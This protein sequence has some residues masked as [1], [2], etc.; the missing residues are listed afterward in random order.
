[1]A[2]VIS[3]FPHTLAEL[4]D[5]V[6]AEKKILIKGAGTSTVLPF[7]TINQYLQPEDELFLVSIDN[8]P[9]K[10]IFNESG[11]LEISG[12]VSWSEAR[13]FLGDKKY[14]L[15]L[16]PT[17]TSAYILAGLATQ[18]SGERSFKFGPLKNYV[19]K[20]KVIDH[21]G[22][23]CEYD[24]EKKYSGPNLKM[25]ND[26]Y[27]HF[28]NTML[29]QTKT[30]VDPF[31]GSEGQ[32]GIIV[33]CQLKLVPK[34]KSLPFFVFLPPW[35]EGENC[36][37]H[38]EILMWVKTQKNIISC[39]LMDH[40]SLSFISS[41]RFN[42]QKK[43]IIFFDVDINFF[44]QTCHNLLETCK[45]INAEDV[46]Q[47][48]IAELNALRLEIPRKVADFVSNNK[49]LKKGTDVQVQKEDFE[50]LLINYK[51]M[52]K[53]LNSRGLKFLLFG[54][55]GDCHLHFNILPTVEDSNFCD[56]LLDNFY[57][58]MSKK[59]CMLFAEHGIGLIKQKYWFKYVSPDDQRE[60]K[61][62]KSWYDPKNIFNPIGYM[63]KV[64]L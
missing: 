41:E 37:N 8:L 39:E 49:L 38:V 42:K 20:L 51:K 55:F 29:L 23:I 60:I 34:I 63:S 27:S 58:E 43:D 61:K 4:S 13:Y 44:E 24:A 48:E 52:S 46:G 40:F 18:A 26:S 32:L 62:L 50:D 7:A 1:M 11:L 5:L 6:A 15:P 16:W 2:K 59:S 28:K 10:L 30:E 14:D 21:K 36:K 25:A 22:N 3:L 45:N 17:E 54:H 57:D 19:S 47:I 12:P 35:N 31:I 9:K 33:E 53:L 56:L 64:N